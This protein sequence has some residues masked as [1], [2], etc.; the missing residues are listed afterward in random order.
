MGEEHYE[1][2]ARLLLAVFVDQ[3]KNCK[4]TCWVKHA[5]PDKDLETQFV[6]NRFFVYVV[7][8]GVAQVWNSRLFGERP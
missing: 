5:V 2:S 7:F 8:S 3:V 4:V 1:D 6:E